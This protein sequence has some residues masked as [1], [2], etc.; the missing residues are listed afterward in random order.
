MNHKIDTCVPMLG[1]A[2][3]E[4][5]LKIPQFI[6]EGKKVVL[7]ADHDDLLVDKEKNGDITGFD[8]AGPRKR[9]FFNPSQTSAAIVTCGG[10]CPGLNNVI[11]S[12]VRTLSDQYG[13]KR[14]LGVRYGY[15]GLVPDFNHGFKELNPGTV[16]DLH[17][18]GGTI[19]GSSRGPQDVSVIVDTLVRENIDILFTVG[20]DGTMR[21]AHSIFEEVKKRG[22]K[23]SIAGIPKTIDNDISFVYKSFGFST[24]VMHATSAVHGAHAEAVGAKNGIGLVKVMG[25][26]SGFIA[27]Y[28]ALAANEV[29]FVLIPEVKFRMEGSGAFLET[30]ERRLQEKAHAV[31]LVAEG[32]GQEF[33][34]LTG[35]KDA[36]GNVKKG[37]IGILIKDEIQKYFKSK[38]KSVT[39]KYID[40]SYII[41]SMPA[42]VDDAVYSI[43]LSQNAVHGAMAG[44]TNFLVGYWNSYFTFVPMQ[45][46]TEKRKKID[47]EG[48][49]WSMVKEATGQ[50]DM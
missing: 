42:S 30:L 10:L 50:P 41:R 1:E 28:T 11:Q 35:E 31:V 29:N 2:K 17:T 5:P 25:R 12:I 6:E 33:F 36:S 23:I 7:Y 4:S 14:I 3:Y 37:D 38:G 24:A 19:L 27:A 34:E 21:G 9:L 47:P 48:Y 45:L 20:G 26:D 43:M 13:V 44:K 22:L 8:N 40:P 16:G 39:L 15:E 46:A 18:K 32:A 49:L